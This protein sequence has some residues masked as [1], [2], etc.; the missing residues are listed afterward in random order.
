MFR[1]RDR[2]DQIC[3]ESE[4]SCAAERER[5][6]G[7]T[8]YLLLINRL[9]QQII[10]ILLR[11]RREKVGRIRNGGKNPTA[12][13]ARLDSGARSC[14]KICS[15]EDRGVGILH[16]RHGEMGWG[17]GWGWR[18]RWRWRCSWLNEGQIRAITRYPDDL[19]KLTCSHIIFRMNVLLLPPSTQL[20]LV[21]IES[22]YLIKNT[23]DDVGTSSS[24]GED[25]DDCSRTQYPRRSKGLRGDRQARGRKNSP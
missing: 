25:Y 14:G 8:V 1:V 13:V 10:V 22:P 4:G 18:W 11:V 21:I 3:L 12:I 24:L 15:V 6:R 16:L 5:G 7:P 23:H 19:I 20:V 9:L 17:W 2:F